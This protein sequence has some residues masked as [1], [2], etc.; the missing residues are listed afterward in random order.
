[1]N[2]FKD[3]LKTTLEILKG[4]ELSD[5]YCTVSDMLND[6]NTDLC[7]CTVTIAVKSGDTTIN[8]ATIV[9]KKGTTTIT[10]E[11][12]GTYILKLG[13]YDYT[14]TKSGY[15][16]K[17]GTISI[18]TSDLHTTTKTSNIDIVAVENDDTTE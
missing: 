8:D 17:T 16:Y 13:T 6:F 15:E 10:A 2:I 9:I 11:Q 4:V 18:T 3:E 12:N 5:D 14:V 7:T 1:M